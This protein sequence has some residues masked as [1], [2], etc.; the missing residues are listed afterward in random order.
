[1]GQRLSFGFF[2]AMAVLAWIFVFKLAPETKGRE[3]EEIRHYWENGGNA[4]VEWFT[5]NANGTRAL[6]N[7]S[8]TGALKSFKR[9]T[10]AEP[11]LPTTTPTLGVARSG[12]NV[13]LTYTGTL[14]SAD[15]VKGP[16]SAVAGATSP[17]TVTPA[18]A[19]KFYRAGQ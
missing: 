17:F 6:V 10:V 2:A 3:L 9:R 11:G 18:G 14:Q 5:V 19:G 12:G 7:G 16:Y 4:Y 8:Q 15:T 1:L 13:V